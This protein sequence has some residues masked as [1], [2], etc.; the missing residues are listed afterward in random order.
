MTDDRRFTNGLLYDV[1]HVLESHGYR[2]P[3]DSDGDRAISG[4][5]DDLWRLC[6]TFEGHDSTEDHS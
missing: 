5:V 4:A 3:E 2:L 1:V 6:H